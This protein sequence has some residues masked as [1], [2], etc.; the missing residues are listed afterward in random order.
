MCFEDGGSTGSCRIPVIFLDR[1]ID[2]ELM[3]NLSPSTCVWAYHESTLKTKLN[4][5]WYTRFNF[6]RLAE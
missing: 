1:C 6:M 4:S 3:E 2:G 5:A